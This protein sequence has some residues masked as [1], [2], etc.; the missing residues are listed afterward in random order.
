MYRTEPDALKGVR[1]LLLEVHQVRTLKMTGRATD[2]RKF[3]DFF[4]Y[5]FQ[6]LGFRLFYH[7]AN[8]GGP[9]ATDV[10]E[11]MVRLGA[12]PNHCCFELGLVQIID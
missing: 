12:R 3:Q 9:P 8:W 4:E 1:M 10:V 6:R 7:H 2:L 5:I 11:K